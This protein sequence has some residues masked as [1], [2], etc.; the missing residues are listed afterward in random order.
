[1]CSHA[2]ARSVIKA[3]PPA[4]GT[5]LGPSAAASILPPS[6]LTMT[7]VQVARLVESLSVHV[8]PPSQLVSISRSGAGLERVVTSD[9][10]VVPLYGSVGQFK[11][12]PTVLADHN[13]TVM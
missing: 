7:V 13:L 8:L 9:V 6:G 1:M 4:A 3:P 12:V 11:G 2:H 5:S 10:V